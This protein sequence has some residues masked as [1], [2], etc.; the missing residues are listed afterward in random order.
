[1]KSILQICIFYIC[2]IL[3]SAYI[4]LYERK[5]IGHVQ[6]R[7]GPTNCGYCGILQPIADAV[8][9]IYNKQQDIG[10]QCIVSIF[11][12]CLLLT[13]SLSQLTIIPLSSEF[14]IGLKEL[15][16]VVLCQTTI[17]LS[18]ILI[19]KS[20]TSKYAMIGGNRAYINHICSHLIFIVSIIS[21]NFLRNDCGIKYAV[22]AVVFF[23]MLL[24]S[25]NRTPFDLTDAESEIVGGAYVD[26]GGIL[27]AMIYLSGYLNLLFISAFYSVLFLDHINLPIPYIA[28]LFI[29]T[30]II[31]SIIILIR[32][33][34]PR[35]TQSQMIK[36][37]LYLICITTL[38]I[39]F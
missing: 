12:I 15:L 17:A 31:V 35:Y 4:S 25:S 24:I 27:F 1:M 21:M 33:I 37:S 8:K 19:G 11:A 9:L 6:L 10:S 32:A 28:N 13:A 29:K 14:N 3:I 39:L 26:Y 16:L 30:F 5:L 22:F 36:I 2:C 20:S 34:L 18:E 23:I 7:V 38:M